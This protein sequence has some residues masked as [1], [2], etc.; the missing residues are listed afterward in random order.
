MKKF[1]LVFVCI[2]SFLYIDNIKAS[3]YTYRIKV[4][5]NQTNLRKDPGG[6]DGTRIGLLYVNDYYVLKDD[7]LYEDVNNHEECNG[8]WYH[9][10]YY[11][12]VDGYV[13]SDDVELVISYSNDDE[14]PTTECEIAL[15]EASFPSSYWGGL[16]SLKEKH[17]SW[18]FQALK[19]DLDWEYV[20]EKESECGRNYIHSGVHDKTFFDETCKKTSPGEYVAPSQNGVA[21][22]MDPRNSFTEKYVFQFLDQSYDKLLESN[23]SNAVETILNGADFNSYHTS[24]GNNLKDIII[25]GSV[26]KASPIAIASKMRIELGV[27]TKLENLYKGIYDGYDSMYLDYYN[28]FNFGVSDS[29]VAQNGATYCGLSY[30]YKAGWKGVDMAIKGGISQFSNGYILKDQYTGYL[31]KFNVATKTN[32][33]LFGHQYMTNLAGAMS[34]ASTAYSAYS[35]NN[36]LELNL[37]F[38]VPVYNKMNTTISNSGNGAISDDNND[39]TPKPSTIPISTIVTSSGYRYSSKYI[40]KIAIGTEVSQIKSAIE[41]VG[42]NATVNVND[43]NGNPKLNGLIATGDKI[44]IN[45]DTDTETLEAII[46]G[47][48]SGDGVINA[49]DLLQV[50]KSILE[51]YNLTGASLEAADTSGDGV[52]NAL[53]LLQVQKNILGTYEIEQ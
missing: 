24:L 17:P 3:E 33:A 23:Y 36:L 25:G 29:C 42:G 1:F 14:K 49:L 47:D 46:K 35:K 15:S 4:I 34:E 22:Y 37:I 16:C 7:K 19:L 27:G 28:F 10:T 50:Q 13:C 53:D 20:V 41:A 8:N 11:T 44:I 52:I 30:A 9:M 48:T 43:A 38:K 26:D 45:N 39:D 2:L 5:N 21:Y 40:S 12:D 31:Q 18:N 32:G 6:T 51:T